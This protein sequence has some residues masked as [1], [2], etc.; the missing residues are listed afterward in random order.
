MRRRLIAGRIEGSADKSS[1][2]LVSIKPQPEFLKVQSFIAFVA[3]L[4]RR[5]VY[6]LGTYLFPFEGVQGCEFVHAE[7][8]SVLRLLGIFDLP[9]RS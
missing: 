5:L 1:Y 8:L 2:K 3:S 7:I 4:L 6:H 9:I